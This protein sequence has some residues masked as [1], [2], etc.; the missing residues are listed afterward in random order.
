MNTTPIQFIDNSGLKGR[1]AQYICIKVDANKVLKS[2]KSSLFS[3]EWLNPDGNIRNVEE[4]G[5]AEKEKFEAVTHQ[6]KNG[7]ALEHPILGI[8]VLDNI[9]I[10]SRRDIFLTLAAHGITEISV[11]VLEQDEKEFENYLAK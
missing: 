5:A 3:F 8:G 10:G 1:E 9:E 6:Y 2:W 11:H 7:K 4:L